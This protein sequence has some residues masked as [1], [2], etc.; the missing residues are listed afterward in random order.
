[1]SRETNEPAGPA[2]GDGRIAPSP[3][4]WVCCAAAAIVI[5]GLFSLSGWRSTP[6]GGLVAP[7]CGIVGSL[8]VL[9]GAW[10]SITVREELT[11][12]ALVPS[13]D[14]SVRQMTEE[15]ARRKNREMLGLLRKEW[16]YYSIGVML[17]CVSFGIDLADRVRG[18]VLAP[19]G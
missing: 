14:A 1:M 13:F 6:F 11:R 8:V 15:F 9:M 10:C 19:A 4:W 16:R 12:L 7:A 2:A 3:L 5:V 18:Y 17:L